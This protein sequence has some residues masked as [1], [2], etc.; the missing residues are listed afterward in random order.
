M[1]LVLS[2]SSSH[3][4]HNFC[5][6]DIVKLLA[7]YQILAMHCNIAR[8]FANQTPNS[9][10]QCYKLT[11]ILDSH[12]WSVIV[13]FVC[14]YVASSAKNKTDADANEEILTALSKRG[15]EALDVLVESL[16]AEEEVHKKLIERIRKGRIWNYYYHVFTLHIL[17]IRMAY[18]AR[19]SQVSRYILLS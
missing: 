14:Y 15:P 3:L 1:V 6:G 5:G 13:S 12:S 17:T 9:M 19:G 11:M 10:F 2:K 18:T 4:P 16:E 7:P 8:H